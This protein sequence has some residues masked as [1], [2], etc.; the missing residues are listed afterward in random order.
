MVGL[1]DE[2]RREHNGEA[3]GGHFAHGL[4]SAD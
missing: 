2:V 1:L 3:V 4:V